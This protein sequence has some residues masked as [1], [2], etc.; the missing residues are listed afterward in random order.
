MAEPRGLFSQTDDVFRR[1]F[2]G[3]RGLSRIFPAGARLDR[4]GAEAE[5]VWGVRQE[6]LKSISCVN[7]SSGPHIYLI[8]WFSYNLGPAYI[9]SVSLSRL[10]T[11]SFPTAYVQSVQHSEAITYLQ[12]ALSAS[13]S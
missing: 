3:R 8:R 2:V 1:R 11:C 13:S 5:V 4:V 10:T 6:Y 9:L 7:V 12:D